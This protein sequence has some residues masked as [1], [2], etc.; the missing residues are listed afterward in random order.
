MWESLPTKR[1]ERGRL[2]RRL[3]P[4]ENVAKWLTLSL[5]GR[6]AED[7]WT[8]TG[9]QE[10]LM[11]MFTEMILREEKDGS[12]SLSCR[13]VKMREFKSKYKFATQDTDSGGQIWIWE[14][15]HIESH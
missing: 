11:K 14:S 10:T 3:H 5:V 12:H 9:G 7:F 1:K 8:A 15:W 6:K 13:M 4:S 2:L